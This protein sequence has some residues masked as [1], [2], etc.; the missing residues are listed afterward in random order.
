VT[1]KGGVANVIA[2]HLKQNTV[3]VAEG[4]EGDEYIITRLDHVVNIYGQ[5]EI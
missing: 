4:R 1:A 5:Q 3:K 2:N